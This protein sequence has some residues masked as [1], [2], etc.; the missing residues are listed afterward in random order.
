[1]TKLNAVSGESLASGDSICRM[2]ALAARS[3]GTFTLKSMSKSILSGF[4]R[5]SGRVPIIR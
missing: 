4:G 1:M 5:L 3:P 2:L